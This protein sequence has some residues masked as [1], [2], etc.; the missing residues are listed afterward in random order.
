MD[1]VFGRLMSSQTLF[2]AAFYA[3]RCE[4][5][6][7]LEEIEIK[8]KE[9]IA[10]L[11]IAN[12]ELQDAKKRMVNCEL[13]K[14]SLDAAIVDVRRKKFLCDD[15]IKLRSTLQSNRMT[16]IM[17]KDH[18]CFLKKRL[19]RIDKMRAFPVSINPTDF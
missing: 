11:Q 8:E 17:K 13:V 19:T 1:Y 4:L 12:I 16:A 7:E 6:Q 9:C 2:S 18:L 14:S 15:L 5:D 3:K 10:M